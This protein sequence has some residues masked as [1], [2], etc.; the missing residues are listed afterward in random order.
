M[1]FL[2]CL[3]KSKQK[4]KIEK[5]AVTFYDK[6]GLV[7][8]IR[9]LKQALNL[10]LVLQKKAWLKIYMDMNTELRKI[11]KNVFEKDSF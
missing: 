3:K 5:L 9:N 10:G 7:L 11:V 1:A 4:K 6:K 2:F 8:H